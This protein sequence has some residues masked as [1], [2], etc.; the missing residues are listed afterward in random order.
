MARSA[1]YIE[2]LNALLKSIAAIT[3]ADV[4]VDSSKEPPHGFLLSKC[5]SVNLYP[6]HLVR[7]CRAVAF[8][9][10]R[11]RVRPEIYWKTEHM[12]RFSPTKSATDWMLTNSLMHLLGR[13]AGRYFRIKYED[14]VLDPKKVSTAL[15]NWVG[16]NITS[17]S[18]GPRVLN[19]AG[20]HELS[21]NPM[22][23]KQEFKITP[24]IEW[25]E[26][27]ATRDKIVTTAISASLLLKYGYG[28]TI[29]AT[30]QKDHQHSR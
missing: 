17:P 22:R 2:M 21:G 18:N 9:Q 25:V 11:I 27:M 12:P 24:D 30:S 6:L 14:M 19:G 29:P 5:N 13:T 4:I 26:S 7:D 1:E 23:F 28:L 20:E 10:Q 8:S 15:L 3:G 16:V